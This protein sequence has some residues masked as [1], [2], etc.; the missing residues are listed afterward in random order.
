MRRWCIYGVLAAMTSLPACV[1]SPLVEAWSEVR[2]LGERVETDSFFS[3]TQ[4]PSEEVPLPT[5]AASGELTLRQSMALGLKYSPDLKSFAWEVR[6]AEARILQ[7]GRWDNPE[8]D[9]EFENF[10]GSGAV[11][12]SGFDF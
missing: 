11:S 10:G 8:L 6:A 2:P 12:G 5:A 4:A 9:V 7:A 3:T 1:P